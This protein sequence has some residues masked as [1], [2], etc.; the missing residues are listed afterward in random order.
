MHFLEF[1]RIN[2]IW[3][4]GRSFF[5]FQFWGGRQN[6]Y[7]K[8]FCFLILKF[9]GL[10]FMFQCLFL[11]HLAIILQLGDLIFLRGT[12]TL[13]MKVIWRLSCILWF[14]WFLGYLWNMWLE[15]FLWILR[16]LWS[17]RYDRFLGCDWMH[18][19]LW[20]LWLRRLLFN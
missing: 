5:T 15:W 3:R 17:F 10:L 19:F 9:W 8:F 12:F 18:W 14:L 16:L 6:L 7:L 20:F 2:F 11:Y 1:F 13:C 4:W